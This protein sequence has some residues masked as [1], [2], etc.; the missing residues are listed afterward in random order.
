MQELEAGYSSS[1]LIS[2]VFPLKIL[3]MS[4]IPRPGILIEFDPDAIEPGSEISF[5]SGAENNIRMEYHPVSGHKINQAM[6]L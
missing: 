4:G 2:V 3:S 6:I 5:G 1:S